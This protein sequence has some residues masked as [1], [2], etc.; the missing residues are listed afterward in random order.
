MNAYDFVHMALY[1]MGGLIRGKTKLQKIIYFLGNKTACL[2]E[3]SYR[4][5][6]Y[7]PYSSDVA[8]AAGRLRALGFVEQNAAGGGTVDSHGF[9]VVRYDY[10]LNE[11]GKRVAELKAKRYSEEWKKLQTAARVLEA[12]GDLDYVKLSIAA[13]TYFMLDQKQSKANLGELTNLAERF[14]WSVKPEE[15]SEAAEFLE[16]MGLVELEH[17]R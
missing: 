15:I 10:S 3:L 8:E 13:K 9:E 5:H 16:K 1:A 2:S 4:A 6:Y 11:E 17:S 14:G 7:G 12:A